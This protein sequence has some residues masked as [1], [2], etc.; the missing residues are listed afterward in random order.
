MSLHKAYPTPS[1]H[2]QLHRLFFFLPLVSFLSLDWAS[3]P[4]LFMVFVVVFQLGR[5]MPHLCQVLLLFSPHLLLFHLLLPIITLVSSGT[6][7]RFHLWLGSASTLYWCLVT[8]SIEHP[9]GKHNHTCHRHS[10]NN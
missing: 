9:N 10:H 3:R 4:L 7:T 6:M 8:F 1:C 2:H 5:R